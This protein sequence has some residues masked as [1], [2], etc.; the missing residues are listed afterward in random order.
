MPLGVSSHLHRVHLLAHRDQAT[1][2]IRS[3]Y[4]D[5][6][7]RFRIRQGSQQN[8]IHQAENCGVG[9]D[10]QR[11]GEHGN[12]GKYRRSPQHSGAKTNIG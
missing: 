1:L 11:Q 6:L 10:S 3:R 5:Q 2:R 7:V 8:S 4:A 9:A 12:Q